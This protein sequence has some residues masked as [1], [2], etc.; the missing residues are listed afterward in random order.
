MDYRRAAI[1]AKKAKPDVML[2]V[3]LLEAQKPLSRVDARSR[4]LA[5]GPAR[6]LANL[7]QKH[8]LYDGRPVRSSDWEIV[9]VRGRRDSLAFF[10]DLLFGQGPSST[11]HS[12]HLLRSASGRGHSTTEG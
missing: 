7:I 6:S 2:T 1:T 10:E 9:V 11:P 3:Q 5:T 4:Y 8:V 12:D